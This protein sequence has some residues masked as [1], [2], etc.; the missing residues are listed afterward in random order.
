MEP[1][2]LSALELRGELKRWE[3]RRNALLAAFPYLED[4][5]ASLTAQYVG[6][7]EWDELAE[8]NSQIARLKLELIRRDQ[9]P[10]VEADPARNASRP[11]VELTE[12]EKEILEVIHRGPRGRQYCRALD[13]A[14]IKPRRSGLW[15]DGPGTYLGAYDEGDPWRQR[16]QDE[17]SKIRRKAELATRKTLAKTLAS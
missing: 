7:P 4:G 1:Q 3:K 12:R 13:H 11:T 2:P 14:G 15:K 10:I 8:A 5:G 17:K 6:G 9:A 16:I